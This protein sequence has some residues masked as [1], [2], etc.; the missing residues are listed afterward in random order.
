MLTKFID[1]IGF[2][3]Y[4]LIKKKKEKNKCLDIL[5]NFEKKS[6]FVIYDLL[7]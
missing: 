7:V 6:N 4:H 3:V 1:M 5:N 2:L